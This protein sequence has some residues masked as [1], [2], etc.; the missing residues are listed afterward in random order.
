MFPSRNVLNL[1]E[2]MRTE[3]FLLR[4][5]VFFR[6][7]ITPAVTETLVKKGFKVNVE[8]NAGVDAKFRNSDYQS[9]GAKIVEDQQ[10]F[11]SGTN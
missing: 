7:S 5:C 11:S 3:R 2:S 10:A 4:L 1:T 9:A 6:V 8:E